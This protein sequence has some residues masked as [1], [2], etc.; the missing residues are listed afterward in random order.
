MQGRPSFT[1]PARGS[2]RL[3]VAVLGPAVAT[4]IAQAT[5]LT[6][7]AAASLYMLAVVGAAA[8][9][10]FLAGAAAAVLSFLGLNYYF[11]PPHHTLT[12]G[13]VEDLLA[14]FVFLIVAVIVGSLFARTLAERQRAERREQESVLLNTFTTELLSAKDITSVAEQFA[15]TAVDRYALSSCAIELDGLAPVKAASS[16]PGGVKVEFPIKAA[17]AHRGVITVVSG[18][19]TTLEEPDRRLLMAFA[20]Q[21]G[22]A[23]ERARLDVEARRARTDAEISQIRAALFSSVTH[24]LRT[25]LSSIKAGVTSLMDADAHHDPTQERELLQTMLEETDRLNRLV[26]NILNLARARAGALTLEVELTPFEDVVESVLTRLRPRLAAYNLRAMIREGLPAI[27][28]DPIQ[29]DQA[30]TNIIENALRHSPAGGEITVAAAPWRGGVQVRVADRGP[31]IPPEDRERV[32]EPFFRGRDD[33]VPGGT[34]L[35]LAIAKAVV[36]AHHG[37]IVIEGAPGGGAAV[38]IE[39][40]PG[41]PPEEAPPGSAPDKPEKPEGHDA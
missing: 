8:L 21:L 16:R 19:G 34:G 33:R 32:F 41:A 28:V 39:L 26:G 23:A 14:L 2:A 1:V 27:W 4:G 9:G 3:I 18:N 11:T 30:L 22:L 13:K 15:H 31:G 20:G 17:G 40:P 10:G 5:G 24:D 38:V 29:M 12:V 6:G 35:G 36:T 7:V 25:P 37:R